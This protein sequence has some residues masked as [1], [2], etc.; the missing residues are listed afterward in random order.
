MAFLKMEDINYMQE[1]AL[2]N[3]YSKEINTSSYFINSL[4]E[5]SKLNNEYRNSMKRFYKRLNESDSSLSNSIFKEF[6]S[7][8]S[9]IIDKFDKCMMDNHS[10]YYSSLKRQMMNDRNSIMLDKNKVTDIRVNN[11]YN[12]T[13]SQDIPKPI[14]R[15]LYYN[16]VDKLQKI[17]KNNTLSQEQKAMNLLFIYNELVDDLRGGFF[18]RF[19]GEILD[20][21]KEI[22]AIDYADTLFAI[23]RDGGKQISTVLEREDI[24]A[25][26]KRFKDAK[27]YL[28]SVERDRDNIIRE[29]NRIRK[30]L[31]NIKLTDVASLLGSNAEEINDKV[32]RYIR[33]KTEQLLNM[34]SIHTMAYTAKLDAVA[35]LYMQDKAILCAV[36]DRCDASEDYASDVV[37]MEGGKI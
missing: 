35:S 1:S 26:D 7:A 28:V 11:I 32:Q 21:N 3:T 20:M 24:I 27:T 6:I 9:S 10:N 19:R 4:N 13:I 5:I 25:I 2:E 15:N 29:Y 23:Y 36:I 8:I 22:S 14:G 33:L 30:D 31:N 34:C 37:H 18:D 12:F 16:E 17:L